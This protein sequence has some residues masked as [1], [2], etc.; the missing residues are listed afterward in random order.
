MHDVTRDDGHPDR[1]RRANQCRPIQCVQ[2]DFAALLRIVLKP[3]HYRKQ[4]ETKWGDYFYD[5]AIREVPPHVVAAH[6]SGSHRSP[7]SKLLDLIKS[8]VADVAK[9]RPKRE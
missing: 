2:K 3:R 4:G 1:Y 8:I 9:Q 6:R 5:R 7:N